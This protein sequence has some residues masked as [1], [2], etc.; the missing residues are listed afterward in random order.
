[1]TQTRKAR[2]AGFIII[3]IPMVDCNRL[4]GSDVYW[5]MSEWIYPKLDSILVGWSYQDSAKRY[6]NSRR[7]ICTFLLHKCIAWLRK[8]HES[9]GKD[10]WDWLGLG[11]KIEDWTED[12]RRTGIGRNLRID[13]GV[14]R[15]HR[16]WNLGSIVGSG[17]TSLSMYD[18]ITKSITTPWILGILFSKY[19]CSNISAINSSLDSLICDSIQIFI[20][21]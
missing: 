9:I 6:S 15:W 10:S 7:R 1:M 16:I 2:K 14:S 19:G 12:S 8:C 4:R 5:Q 18:V 13:S 20:V 3:W 11:L 17:P 21:N